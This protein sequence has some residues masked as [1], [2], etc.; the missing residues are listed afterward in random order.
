M[1]AEQKITPWDVEVKSSGDIP[2]KIDYEKVINQFG[3]QK[4]ETSLVDRLEEITGRPAHYFFRRNIVFAHRDFNLL[5]DAVA[6]K[7]PFYLYTGRGPSSSAMHIGHAIPFLLCKYIQDVFRIPFVIQ[8]TDDEKFLWK[9]ME[10][11]EAVRYGR[12]NIKDIIAFGFDPALTYIFSNVE[13]SHR[14]EEVTLKIS[15]SINLNEAFK[16]FGFDMSSNVG[17]IAF[18]SKEI[19]PCFSS[20]FGF[21]E[22]GAMCLVP[23][24]IDQDP[25]FRLARDK[26][27]ILKEKKPSSIYVS[28]L[29]DLKGVNRKMSA[30]D[31]NSSIYLCDSAEQIRKKINS[32]AFSGGRETLEEHKEKGGNIEVDVPF[33]YLRYFLD[34]DD[35]LERY[36]CGYICGDISSGDMKKRCIGAVQGFVAGYQEARAR[37]TDEDLRIFMDINKF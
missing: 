20:S 34:N 36:R 13:S 26:A 23:A 27:K 29:P 12:E 24:A 25:Y 5:L 33:E 3:C 28:L 7:K 16:V 1:D 11:D 19:A 22:K 10:L 30:S 32:Y 6:S 15:K 2:V 31:P 9:D 4:F 8:I 35:E 18:P 14:F 21:V 17:Q 37:V